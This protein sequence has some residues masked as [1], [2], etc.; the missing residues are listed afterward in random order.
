MTSEL[1]YEFIR[2]TRLVDDQTMTMCEQ[3]ITDYYVEFKTATAFVQ[4]GIDLKDFSIQR[5]G[6]FRV[7]D[8]WMRITNM[9]WQCYQVEIVAE[10][11]LKTIVKGNLN[12]PLVI[13]ANC[14]GESFY[15]VS[16]L[17]A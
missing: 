3:N 12:N 10:Y 4:K 6:I 2:G 13:L 9:T 14:V 1:A 16:A 11:T 8:S 15:I 7:T 17:A 5:E